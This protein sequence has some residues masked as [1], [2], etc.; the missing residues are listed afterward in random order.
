MRDGLQK[1][2][3]RPERPFRQ[4]G[5][6]WQSNKLLAILALFY[7][8]IV[9]GC[10]GIASANNSK[11]HSISPNASVQLTLTSLNFGTTTVGKKMAQSVSVTNAGSSSVNSR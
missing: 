8:A 1:S 3:N 4:F 6:G 7:V 11:K 2:G 10:T 9:A 5:Y